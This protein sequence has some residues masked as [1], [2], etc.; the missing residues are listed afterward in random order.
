MGSGEVAAAGAIEAQRTGPER[1]G[2][3]FAGRKRRGPARP[4]RARGG[5]AVT[6]SATLEWLGAPAISFS[7]LILHVFVELCA[8]P[9]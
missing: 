3:A 8:F 5:P 9:A 7:S 4:L 1:E 6:Y 2:T